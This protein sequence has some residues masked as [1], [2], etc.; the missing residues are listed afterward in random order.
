MER[1]LLLA[2]VLTF[3]VLTAYQWLVPMS[4]PVPASTNPASAPRPSAPSSAPP[5]PAATP[6][7]VPPAPLGEPVRADAAERTI[8]IE[9]GVVR[10]V[11]SNR[12]ATLAAWELL[13]Y[14]AA[15]GRPVDLV[16]HD[17]PLDQPKPFSLRLEDVSKSARLNTAL[18][19]FQG[20]ASTLSAASEPVTLA[21]EYED[22]AGLHARK[23]FTL[24]PNSYEVLVTATVTDGDRALNPFVQWGPGLGDVLAT[25]GGGMF[26]ST[27]KA[28][29]LFSI[30]GDVERIQA[31]GNG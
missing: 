17:V 9:N 15:D 2:I 11:F 27:R 31:G 28:E 21:F 19:A 1:R 5:A 8:T 13:K 26:M 16:P 25:G 24:K 30:D 14:A 18:F 10:A 20:N 3:V 7:A 29:A 6:P 22:A 4:Q 23:Q 12:G